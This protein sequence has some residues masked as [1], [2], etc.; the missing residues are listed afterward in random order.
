MGPEALAQGECLEQRGDE[1]DDES[2]SSA[3][4]ENLS[5]GV[6]SSL[7]LTRRVGG[8]GTVAVRSVGSPFAVGDVEIIHVP[9]SLS[10]G[11]GGR[12]RGGGGGEGRRGS[13]S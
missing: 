4:F 7:P 6:E 3:G 2:E 9:S 11:G 1:R 10:R 5:S 8:S 13:D 12:R